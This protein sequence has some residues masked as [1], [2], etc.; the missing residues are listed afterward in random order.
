MLDV[1]DILGELPETGRATQC[2]IHYS[3]LVDDDGIMYGATH[4]S[5]PAVGEVRY[6]PW[7]TFNDPDRSYLGALM[8]AF[9]LETEKIVWTDRL[10]PWEGC[11][12]L[13]LDRQ[14]RW[15]YAIGYPRDHFYRYELKTGER[16]DF[17][18][19]GSVNPQT[20]WLDRRGTAYTTC[21]DG[22][23]VTFDPESESL[24]ETDLHLPAA[25]YQNCWH[26]VVYDAVRVP[27]SDEVVGVT[28][29]VDPHLFRF[30]PGDS[31]R[32]A[33]VQNYGAAR[34]GFDGYGPRGLNTDHAGG[35]VFLPDGSLLYGATR[36]ADNGD[37]YGRK[38][39]LHRLNIDTGESEKLEDLTTEQDQPIGYV[40]RAARIGPRDVI[41]G[42]VGPR[43]TGI[44]HLKL[45]EELA[46]GSNG[47]TPRRY[48][49]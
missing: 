29:N 12:C 7:A 24:R 25:P 4:L 26:N 19:I 15:L 2:K 1:A 40:S 16:T 49:G 3:L 47:Q 30:S 5:G 36:P 31:E 10:I 21:D 20:I 14:R 48:W 27:E 42:I 35:L 41:F 22:R 34:P 28:W 32:E 45:P 11:R 23:I 33:S 38:C 13:A 6:D 43:P 39:E 8:F 17:G 44:V 46:A 9:N 37:R 18:R